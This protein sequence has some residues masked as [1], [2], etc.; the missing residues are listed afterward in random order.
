MAAITVPIM[1][2]VYLMR[3]K[4]M[5]GMFETNRE[6]GSQ[7]D[8][9]SVFKSSV[10]EQLTIWVAFLTC[11]ESFLFLQLEFVHCTARCTTVCSEMTLSNCKSLFGLNMPQIRINQTRN[12]G[13]I[14]IILS[15]NS[16]L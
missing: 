13:Q 16:C 9:G 12:C 1:H 15:A 4:F 2:S 11:L 3:K 6:L 5:V 10:F 8:N 14:F 7:S